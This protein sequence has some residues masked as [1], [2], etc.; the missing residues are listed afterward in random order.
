MSQIL[1]AGD[2]NLDGV[3][4]YA[5]FQ[6]LE[7]NYGETGTW[8]EQGDFNDEGV[9]NWSDL[10][11]LRTNLDPAAVTPRSVCPDCD[12]RPAE[13]IETGQSPE[14]DG[15]GVTYISDMPWVSSSNGQGA[16]PGQ[17]DQ[18][19]LGDC[20]GRYELLRRGWGSTANSQVD[21]QSGRHV[22]AV[23]IGNRHRQSGRHA[24][25]SSSKSMAMAICSTNHRR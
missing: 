8:W 10:N 2:A 9:V 15:F 14:Y 3:V 19:R 1:P 5:D 13:H 16:G 17:R 6:I 22:F 25:R 4:D 21:R 12:L 20:A 7:S 18:R 24:A 23:P 11:I